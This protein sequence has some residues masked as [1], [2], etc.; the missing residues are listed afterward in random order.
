MGSTMDA[1]LSGLSASI[2][3]DL[4]DILDKIWG[5]CLMLIIIIVLLIIL[6]ILSHIFGS[7]GR[8]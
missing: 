6:W 1:I 5:I 4:A 3:G 8:G 7:G 2:L